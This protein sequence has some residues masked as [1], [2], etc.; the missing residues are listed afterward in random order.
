MGGLGKWGDG[1][2]DGRLAFHGANSGADASLC[3]QPLPTGALHQDR[4]LRIKEKGT[5]GKRSEEFLV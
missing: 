1:E 2:S 3:T 4:E 5:V